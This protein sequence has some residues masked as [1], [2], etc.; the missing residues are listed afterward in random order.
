MKEIQLFALF[1]LEWALS[2]IYLQFHGSDA[3]VSH[4]HVALME[5]M[6]VGWQDPL[7]GS[8]VGLLVSLIVIWT[9]SFTFPSWKVVKLKQCPR[10][11]PTGL[12]MS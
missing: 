11:Y 9:V 12:F 1:E 4:L 8:W 10:V 7:P 3:A 5:K 6:E 2:G